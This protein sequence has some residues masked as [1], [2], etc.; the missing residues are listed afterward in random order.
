M[1]RTLITLALLSV[2]MVSFASAGVLFTL[3]VSITTKART[4]WIIIVEGDNADELKDKGWNI[5]VSTSG[6]NATMECPLNVGVPSLVIDP[7]RLNN[8]DTANPHN[9]TGV[10]VI[11]EDFDNK[12]KTFQV[13]VVS[14][15][16]IDKLKNHLLGLGAAPASAQKLI[17]ID[18]NGDVAYEFSGNYTI[19]A[20]SFAVFIIFGYYKEGTSRT[21]SNTITFYIM[22]EEIPKE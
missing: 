1:K 22:Q 16:D 5:S 13:W 21:Q 17:E 6:T 10:E 20:N 8:T 2:L 3:K 14:F 18:D 12:I 11:S 15:A 7:L 4:P 19:A 9:I